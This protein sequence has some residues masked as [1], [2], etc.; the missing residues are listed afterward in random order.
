MKNKIV[1][2]S[3]YIPGTIPQEVLESHKRIIEYFAPKGCDY[4]QY[5][6]PRAININGPAITK[7]INETD[8]EIYIILY[9]DAIPL[10][11]EIIP[12]F[13]KEARAGKLIGCTGRNGSRHK[14]ASSICVTFSR[15]LYKKLGV[16]FCRGIRNLTPEEIVLEHRDYS[17]KITDWV[18]TDTAEKLT[19]KAE[20]M[21][22]PVIML[23]VTNVEE[24]MWEWPD[25]FFLG[26]GNTF[27]KDIWHQSETWK[28]MSKFM[29]KAYEIEEKIKNGIV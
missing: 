10:N 2:L 29:K 23:K 17:K 13:I 16:D 28:G 19:Y 7:F 14:Y 26:H 3:S 20:E 11:K 5:K 15:E 21:G 4:I 24:V 18:E 12:R 1:I 6:M 9:I 27:E 22:I 25:G 8:Y